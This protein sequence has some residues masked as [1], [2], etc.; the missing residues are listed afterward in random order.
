MADIEFTVE[1]GIATILLNRPERRNAFNQ[2]MVDEW[3]Q[4]LRDAKWDDDV[5]VIV[6]TGAG[7]AFCSGGDLDDLSD[8]RTPIEWKRWLHE[9]I[10]RV[11]LAMEELDKPVIAAVNGAATGAGLD[12]AMHC[13]IRYAARSARFAETYIKVGMMPGDGGAY[14]LPKLVGMGR[15]LELL[16]TGDFVDAVEAERIGLVNKVFDDDALM[17]ETMALARRLADGPPITTR[18]IKRLTYQSQRTDLRTALD[19]VSSHFGVNATTDDSQEAIGA[20]RER[21][22][23]TFQNR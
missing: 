8:D 6:L 17:T 12:M 13:D 1:D 3:S 11:P 10:Q 9:H 2:A 16:L 15:A 23:P 19:M 5:S 14:Y 20:F 18:L 4:F 22:E 21:R 7:K